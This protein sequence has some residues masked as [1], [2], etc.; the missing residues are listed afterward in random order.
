[1]IPCLDLA[2]ARPGESVILH[3]SSNIELEVIDSVGPSGTIYIGR[4][5]WHC[6]K[7]CWSET[8]HRCIAASWIR[9]A[10]PENI[11]D[12][13][14]VG[15]NRIARKALDIRRHVLKRL[16]QDYIDCATTE[17]LDAIEATVPRNIGL[18][19]PRKA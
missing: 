2:K 13:E 19:Q 10:T 7:D 17:Q 1:M 6:L 4:R 5:S 18:L 12:V 14:R 15:R 9:P 3:D 16:M 8:T 11:L